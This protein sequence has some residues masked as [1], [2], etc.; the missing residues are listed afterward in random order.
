MKNVA[1]AAATAADVGKNESAAPSVGGRK[2]LGIFKNVG[3]ERPAVAVAPR[4]NWVRVPEEC[5]ATFGNGARRI[6]STNETSSY[7]HIL[8]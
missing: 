1:T 7:A 2:A 6:A 3:A 8:V 5:A 4:A